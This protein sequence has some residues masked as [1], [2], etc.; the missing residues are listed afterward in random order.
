MPAT[1]Y[2]LLF[3]GLAGGALSV[4]VVAWLA[5]RLL[6]R[7]AGLLAHQQASQILEKARLEAQALTER[8]L[9]DARRETE[10]YRAEAEEELRQK[11][12][13]LNAFAARLDR[14]EDGIDRKLALIDKKEQQLSRN[15]AQAKKLR[16]QAESKLVDIERMLNEEKVKLERL[17]NISPQEAREELLK[18]YER[19]LDH[20]LAELVHRRH[21]RAR[22]EAD[23]QAREIVLQAIQRCAVEVAQNGLV[24]TVDLP[25]DEMKGRIIGREGRNIRT[26][27]K[28]TGVDVLVDDTPGVV[29]ISSYDAVRREIARRA[30]ERLTQDGRI[31]PARIE[32]VV[33]RTQQEVER[34]ILEEAK[35]AAREV[36]VPRLK[37]RELEL[38]GRLA[39][40]TS[41]GQ[42]CLSH[43]VEV[44]ILAGL[45]AAELKLNEPLARRCG[46]LHDI[47]K[48]V[49]HEKEGTHPA[50]GAD[51]AAGFEEPREV[52]NA[53]AAHHED[54]PA[55]TLYA[56]LTQ[57]ADAISASRPGARRENLERYLQRLEQ[58]E[59]IAVS[60]AGVDKAYAVHAGREIRVL[61]HAEKLGEAE[62]SKLA[63]EVA[64][65]VEEQ[66]SYP[67]EVKVTVI[68]EQ[69]F[70][71]YAR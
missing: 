58:L 10:Q 49:D 69:R 5:Q 29:V 17:A 67:G 43:S 38:L 37:P 35:N 41:Y 70:I 19:E 2:L 68:R 24:A 4:A 53:I 13:E 39:F 16:E 30:L 48:S 56:V 28:E 3:V 25:S 36:G 64:R 7:R 59:R 50:I 47:G 26:F 34:Q 62:S 22:E 42:N 55:E 21:E 46:L 54:V 45:M 52:V 57:A 71:E 9:A 31:H 12:R 6:R 51:L 1:G 27:M 8:A 23:A 60:H 65:E 15:E 40:R 14:R 33:H 32:E 63:A 66:L 18:R 61:V 11:R 20:E 44:A